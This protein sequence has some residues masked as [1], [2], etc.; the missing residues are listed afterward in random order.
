MKILL[1]SAIVLTLLSCSNSNEHTNEVTNPSNEK[2]DSK[3]DDN[4]KDGLFKYHFKILD[5][6]SKTSLKDTIYCCTP[7][8]NF[9]E[10]ETEIEASTE[11]TQLGRLAFTKKNLADWHRW[12]NEKANSSHDR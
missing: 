3:S 4:S 7:S 8:I 5:S 6:A 1:K 12:Y 9:M 10:S 2:I 11:G